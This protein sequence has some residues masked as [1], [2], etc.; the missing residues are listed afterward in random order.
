MAS[1]MINISVILIIIIIIIIIIDII[2]TIIIIIIIIIIID[3]III[4]T[5]TSLASLLLP[6]ESPS[7]ELQMLRRETISLPDQIFNILS[8][9]LI[10][11]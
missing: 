7:S 5:F 1:L 8:F 3:I 2:T 9:I 4:I 6:S 11:F 10:T